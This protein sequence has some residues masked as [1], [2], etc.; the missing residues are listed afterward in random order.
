MYVQ[1]PR[2]RQNHTMPR[3]RSALA[4]AALMAVAALSLSGVAAAAPSYPP[5]KNPLKPSAKPKGPFQTHTVCAKGCM[6]KTIQE[7]VNDAKAG[8]TI[9][10]SAGVYKER[11]VI[12]GPNK[13]SIKIIGDPKHPEKVVLEGKGS[14]PLTVP[15]NAV[16]INGSDNIVVNGLTA[17]GYN[18]YGFFVINNN[19]YTFTNLIAKNDGVYGMYAFN[20]VGG[21][22][23]NST[24]A[25]NN[26]SGFYIG[27]T[28]PQTKP[29]RSYIKNVVAYGNVLGYSG[30]NSRY[31]TITK[32]KWFNNGLG[33]VPNALDSEK[34]APF[35]DNVITD[36]DVFFNN[37]N[38]FAA[39]PFKLRA[40]ATGEIAYPVGTGILLFGGRR[41][42]VTK[43][44]IYGNY[45][46]GV[47]AVQQILLKQVDARNLE[48][49]KI[50]DNVFGNGGKNKNGR[51]IFYD[52]DGKDN[53]IGPN[54][55]VEVTV[56]A[57]TS[58]MPCPFT[59]ANTFDSA[60]QGEA[61]SWAIDTTEPAHE[62]FWIKNTQVPVPGVTPLEHWTK[63][64]GVK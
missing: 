29:I 42:D 7:A 43:N 3:S 48:G 17:Q 4:T 51:D 22:M 38:Y 1:Q 35:E 19:G 57:A 20:S 52:G 8:D 13:R 40:G 10:V 44:R 59:G 60:A 23:S 64:I 53:C 55:G 6:H 37:W 54:V 62:K 24:A 39:A 47:G 36:N 2:G 15:N 25:W 58:F 34:Y 11:I 18:G 21:E 32:S 63:A 26:D 50:H 31:V 46:M 56:P 9:K 61:V 33:I 49:N 30:T 12:K 28:P 45:L 5:P 14:K 27:Q 41:T 16:S